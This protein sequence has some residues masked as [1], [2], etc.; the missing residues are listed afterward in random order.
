M[1]NKE[2]LTADLSGRLV[3]PTQEIEWNGEIYWLIG[4]TC[5]RAILVKPF[6]SNSENYAP[7]VEE[8]KPILRHI[9]SLTPVELKE[10]GELAISTCGDIMAGR[11]VFDW[12]D[13]N[14]ID[15]R[16]LIELGLAKEKK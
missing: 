1:N 8:V 14:G 3:N 9:N 7:L 12:F 6:M 10:C 2:I 15:Y 4:I 16:G 5:G 11:E 13:K